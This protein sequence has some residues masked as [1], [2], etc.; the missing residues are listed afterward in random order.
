MPKMMKL[1]KCSLEFKYVGPLFSSLSLT[2]TTHWFA[3]AIKAH[4]LFIGCARI[5]RGCFC[6]CCCS[7]C[8]CCCCYCCI[9]ALG[10]HYISYRTVCWHRK[11]IRE[12]TVYLS[13]I[14]TYIHSLMHQQLKA[15]SK[16]D[17][18]WQYDE[19]FMVY[20]VEQLFQ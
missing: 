14:S 13:I 10:F 3:S 15:V 5:H 1:S 9:S 19:K 8:C 17:I 18:W 12:Q 4:R 2:G 11:D 20:D 7:W 16:G 6:C